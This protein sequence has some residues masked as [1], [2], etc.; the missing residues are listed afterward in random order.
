MHCFSESL[1]SS[2][3]SK[4]NNC[5]K[6]TLFNMIWGNITINQKLKYCSMKSEIHLPVIQTVNYDQKITG[7]FGGTTFLQLVVSLWRLLEPIFDCFLLKNWLTNENKKKFLKKCHMISF[8]R[9]GIVETERERKSE[10]EKDPLEPWKSSFSYLR[11]SSL[12]SSSHSLW[13]QTNHSVNSHFIS[14]SKNKQGTAYTWAVDEELLVKVELQD[15]RQED[16]HESEHKGPTTERWEEGAVDER[17]ET[18]TE[19]TES[20]VSQN[21]KS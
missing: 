10:W 4:T 6:E 20:F 11:C 15:Q 18:E 12:L 7:F 9:G 8:L 16:G 2:N 19:D 17:D 3:Q 5:S 21:S 13:N 1:W 14:K